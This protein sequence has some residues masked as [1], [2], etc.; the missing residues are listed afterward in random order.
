MSK[1]DYLVIVLEERRWAI[2][3]P[4]GRDFTNEEHAEVHAALGVEFPDYR[5]TVTNGHYGRVTIPAKGGI[6]WGPA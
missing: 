5:T 1:P 6:R 4:T 3:L 2:A